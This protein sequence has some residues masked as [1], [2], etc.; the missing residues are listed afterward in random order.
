MKDETPTPL[1]GDLEF[2]RG[3]LSDND[4]TAPNLWA[5]R[6]KIA[7]KRRRALI[8]RGAIGAAATLALTAAGYSLGT[9]APR[10]SAEPIAATGGADYLQAEIAR[11]AVET[12]LLRAQV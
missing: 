3:A 5:I 10:Q 11:L 12:E 1:E 8:L 6:Q 2:L 4:E 7:A 9:R